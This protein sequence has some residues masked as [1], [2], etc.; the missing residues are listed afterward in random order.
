MAVNVLIQCAWRTNVTQNERELPRIALT[1]HIKF[2]AYVELVRSPMNYRNPS[3]KQVV[4]GT[5]KKLAVSCS[6]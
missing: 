4:I 1:S 3:Q 6:V 5:G 2:V